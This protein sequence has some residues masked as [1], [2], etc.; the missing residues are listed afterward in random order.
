LAICEIWPSGQAGTIETEPVRSDIPTLLL[1]GE[2][3]PYT[4]PSWSK[5]AAETLDH[6][7]FYEFPGIGHGPVRHSQCARDIVLAFLADPMTEPDASCIAE[8]RDPDFI[9]PDELYLTPAIYRL[10]VDLQVAPNLF[11][12]GLLGLCLLLFVTKVT[13]FLVRVF[14]SLGQGTEQ[15]SQMD[16]LAAAVAGLNLAFAIA[17]MWVV[18]DASSTNWLLPALGLPVDAAWLF[19]VPRLAAILTL[20]LPIS[21]LR[22]WKSKQW[23]NAQRI[24]HTLFTIAALT[25]LSLLI[26][27][28]MLTIP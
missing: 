21:T 12:L 5:Q 3:D 24:R 6:S 25:F 28:G 23:S 14:R 20:G 7:F 2:Y 11:R 8:M 22:V 19:W 17:L 18:L 27:W 4:P 15:A 1:A 26:H 16:V 10:S 9:T 13:T